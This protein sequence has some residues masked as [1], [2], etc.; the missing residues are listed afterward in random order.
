[1]FI[2]Q[3]L[4][5]AIASQKSLSRSQTVFEVLAISRPLVE[6]IVVEIV[7][8]GRFDAS[9]VRKDQIFVIAYK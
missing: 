4:S 2:Q 3:I 6:L 9:L 1:M 7:W 8:L 5:E